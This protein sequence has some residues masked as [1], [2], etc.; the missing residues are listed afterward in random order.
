MN[1][2]RISGVRRG[3]FMALVVGCGATAALADG[4]RRGGTATTPSTSGG[5]EST[6]ASGPAFFDFAVA[7]ARGGGMTIYRFNRAD[8]RL[9]VQEHLSAADAGRRTAAFNRVHGP[10]D[11]IIVLSPEGTKKPPPP[12]PNG[13]DP[14]KWRVP[15]REFQVAMEQL[16]T[17]APNSA[18]ISIG[19]L[20]SATAAAK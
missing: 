3:I 12:P 5:N 14:G 10:G 6:R 2:W 16:K 20:S 15:E 11:A 8:Q 1:T 13:G 18:E 4:P 19:Q 9:S 17:Q 7:D